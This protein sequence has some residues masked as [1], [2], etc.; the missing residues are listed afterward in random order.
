[1]NAR[2]VRPLLIA[3]LVGVAAV[4]AAGAWLPAWHRRNWEFPLMRAVA[5]ADR[6]RLRTGG[7][8]HR[9]PLSERTLFEEHDPEKVREFV[10]N[11]KINARASGWKATCLCCGGPSIEFYKGGEL[12][13][14]LG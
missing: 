10:A 11:I 5:D 14:T 4:V 8:C 12:L 7:T 9:H 1:M 3:V 13:V 2:R 6:I